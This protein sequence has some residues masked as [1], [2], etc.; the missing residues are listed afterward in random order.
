MPRFKIKVK[1]SQSVAQVW[2]PVSACSKE[3]AQRISMARCAGRGFSPDLQTLT[4]ITEEDYSKLVG[5]AE[6]VY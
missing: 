2:V 5:K 1:S 3:E 6:K 4:Q